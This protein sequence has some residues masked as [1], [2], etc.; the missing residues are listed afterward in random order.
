MLKSRCNFASLS[1]Y[2]SA[3]AQGYPSRAGA[4]GGRICAG[5][6]AGSGGPAARAGPGGAARSAGADREPAGLGHD[7]G[8]RGRRQ[9]A[10]GRAYLAAG[11]RGDRD[12]PQ[13]LR[14]AAVRPAARHRAGLGA[15]PRDER[16]GG[17][18]GIAGDDARRA[19]RLRK[20][21]SRKDQHGLVRRRLD[22]ARRGESCSSC[23]PA[24]T[25]C[26]CPIAALRRR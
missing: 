21:Q 18:A 15:D 19:R 10:A 17:A 22:R 14:A 13:S 12:E 26:T 20:G 24:P 11:R 25:W 16:A 1:L 2:T 4:V 7:A 23:G 5:R 8:N 3:T 9:R 6:R